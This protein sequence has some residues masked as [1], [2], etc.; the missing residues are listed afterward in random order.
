MAKAPNAVREVH[1]NAR[2]ART[3]RA[4][5]ISGVLAALAVGFITA[6]HHAAIKAQSAGV[7]NGMAEL[8]VIAFLVTWVITFVI[9][10]SVMTWRYSARVSR[11]RGDNQPA[12]TVRRHYKEGW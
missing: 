2:S 9:V 1:R 11:A 7:T 3:G 5:K 10:F 12:G 8:V 6:T 4:I